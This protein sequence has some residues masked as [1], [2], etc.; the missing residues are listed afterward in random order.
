MPFL[1]DLPWWF[2]GLR[3]VFGFESKSYKKKELL[4]L[5]RGEILPTLEERLQAK[6]RNYQNRNLLKEGRFQLQQRM[7]N[8]NRQS[9]DKK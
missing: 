4:I 8:Y 6:K 9:K 2:F 3:Y 7:D 1:K 5:I